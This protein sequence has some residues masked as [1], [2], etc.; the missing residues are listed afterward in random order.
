MPESCEKL[1]AQISAPAESRTWDAAAE[2]ALCLRPL[3]SPG[4]EPVPRLDMDKALEAGG[5]RDAAKKAALPA[6][7]WPS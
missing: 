1:F 7:R 6:V 5:R 4:R 3:P 2:W